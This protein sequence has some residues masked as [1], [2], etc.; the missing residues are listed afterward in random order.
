M[1]KDTLR[2]AMRAKRRS[3]SPDFIK[4]ASA[5]IKDN[6]LGLECIKNAHL[7]MVY[8]SAFKEPDTFSL[9]SALFDA[10]KEICVPITNIDTFTITPSR[11]MLLDKLTKGA[12]GIYEPKEKISVP[13]SQIDIAFIPGIAFTSSGDRLGFG[14]GYYDRF[15]E[16][17]KGVK[18]GIGYDFQITDK[19]LTDKHDI[20]M[21]MIVTEKRIYNDF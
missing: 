16:D 20:K 18:I 11:L 7:V 15:L 1:N 5:R 9:I 19:I 2:E 6:V 3:L 10:G 8:L 13:V 21:D 4:N 17:F 14:K 12:Y